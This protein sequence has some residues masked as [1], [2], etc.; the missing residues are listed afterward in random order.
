MAP[1]GRLSVPCSYQAVDLGRETTVPQVSR[2]RSRVSR[3]M[4]AALRG[5]SGVDR[6]RG[7]RDAKPQHGTGIAGHLRGC[8]KHGEFRAPYAGACASG[9]A[10]IRHF[11]AL[12]A[13]DKVKHKCLTVTQACKTIRLQAVGMAENRGCDD[14]HVD[15]GCVTG[16]RRCPCPCPCPCSCPCPC[17]GVAAA[18]AIWPNRR[19][20]ASGAP[21]AS[22]S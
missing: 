12:C 22:A 7:L 17:A 2:P 4:M 6:L 1:S 9:M 19:A 21:G 14:L 15:R 11:L 10:E 3:P 5:P 18:A 20:R 16:D 13:M 8:G